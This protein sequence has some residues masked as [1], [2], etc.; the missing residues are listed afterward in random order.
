MKQPTENTGNETR[1]RLIASESGAAR[2]DGSGDNLSASERIERDLGSFP[3]VFG[4]RG[5]PGR[6][7]RLNAGY[8]YKDDAGQVQLVIEVRQEGEKWEQFGKATVEELRGEIGD[9]REE[10]PMG[11]VVVPETAAAAPLQAQ[12]VTFTLEEVADILNDTFWKAKTRPE[13][14]IAKK[15][16]IAITHAAASVILKVRETVPNWDAGAF[17]DRVRHIPTESTT[18]L[19]ETIARAKREVLE[20]CDTGEI[21]AQ[22]VT[23][24]ADLHQYVDAN[25]FGGAFDEGGHSPDDTDFWNSVQD[26]LDTWI[27]A[28]GLKGA[29]AKD[30]RVERLQGLVA[31]EKRLLKEL[32][33]PCGLC[34]RRAADWEIR[35]ARRRVDHAEAH[36]GAAIRG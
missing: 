25:S 12:A 14:E 1:S 15:G 11:G 5:F 23:G 17:I 36:L 29:T 19:Q 24:F 6:E 7:Y 21:D 32:N 10:E 30:E 16:H 26:A 22:A 3:E 18:E 8:S 34:G 27:K 28:G 2:S 13:A 9:I 20:A 35:A 4:L 31:S 33:T